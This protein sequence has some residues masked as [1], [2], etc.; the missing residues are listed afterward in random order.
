MIRREIQFFESNQFNFSES[1]DCCFVGSAEGVSVIGWEP[2]REYDHIESAWSILGDMKVVKKKL[3]R[4]SPS[5]Q[6]KMPSELFLI[7]IFFHFLSYAAH[8]KSKQLRCMQLIWI[9]SS[10]TTTRPTFHFAIINRLVK[11]LTAARSCH[12]P[13]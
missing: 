11:A 4:L 10:P 12:C 8:T 7:R 1:G 5:T 9:K 2:D 3:V 13:C 6:L